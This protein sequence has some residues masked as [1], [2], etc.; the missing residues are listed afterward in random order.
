MRYDII[1]NLDYE[2]Y[3]E[4]QLKPLFNRIQAMMLE[5]G[6]VMDGRRFTIDQPPAE[7]QAL[8]REVVDTLDSLYRERGE[9]QGIYPWI[10]EFFGFA[11]ENASNLLIPPSE[12]IDVEELADMDGLEVANLFAN[13]QRD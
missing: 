8:A 6:F 11:P 12:E 5:R 1:I 7:A 10:K 3:P 2:N 13:R 9:E 4:A